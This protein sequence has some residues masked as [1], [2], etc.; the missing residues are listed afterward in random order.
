M[1]AA[2][3]LRDKKLW[4][5]FQPHTYSRTKSL[6]NEFSEAFY[7]ADKVILTDIYAAREKDPGDIS[8]KDLAQSLYQKNV[9][10]I[11]IPTFDEIVDYIKD[12]LGPD[13]IFITCGASPINR[14]AETLL[15][16]KD[17]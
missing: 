6:F 1:A 5:A 12:K 11:Y 17:K 8:S 9:D 7:S 4:V 15:E 2:K 10:A 13:D 14:V 16:L 3:N